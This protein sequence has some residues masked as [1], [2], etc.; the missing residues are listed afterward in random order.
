MWWGYYSHQDEMDIILVWF[1]YYKN[2]KEWSL[3]LGLLGLSLESHVMINGLFKSYKQKEVAVD[4]YYIIS[5][6][7]IC[8]K[9]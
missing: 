1:G 5:L 4:L 3:A 7:L 6:R 9:R 8:I 2:S